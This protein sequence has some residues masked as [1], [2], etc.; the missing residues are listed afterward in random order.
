LFEPNGL[1]LKSLPFGS[2]PFFNGL[3]VLRRAA[4]RSSVWTTH[5]ILAM[6]AALVGA[7]LV[8]DAV[9]GSLTMPLGFCAFVILSGGAFGGITRIRLRAI[10]S[11]AA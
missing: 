2:D 10:F 5:T 1:L 6:T 4:P 7:S 11:R 3:L 8:A 9:F